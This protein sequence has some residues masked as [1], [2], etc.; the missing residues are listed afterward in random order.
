VISD[1]QEGAER[2]PVIETDQRLAER[3]LETMGGEQDGRRRQQRED[4]H[5]QQ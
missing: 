1:A 4:H 5:A 2:R 3:K